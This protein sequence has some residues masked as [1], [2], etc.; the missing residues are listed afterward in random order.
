MAM[1]M[2]IPLMMAWRTK[3][4]H[5]YVIP[6]FHDISTAITSDKGIVVVLLLSL[7]LSLGL[8]NL[9]GVSLLDITR[10]DNGDEHQYSDY[11]EHS[12]KEIWL[13]SLAAHSCKPHSD[14]EYAEGYGY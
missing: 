8:P 7:V 3:L 6:W 12:E 13:R 10:T 5:L 9:A 14:D 11:S 4:M 2:W 1:I